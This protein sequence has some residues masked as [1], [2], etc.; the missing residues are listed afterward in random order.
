MDINEAKKLL[1]LHSCRNSDI[2]N[3]K[4]PSLKL[5]ES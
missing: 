3:P 5:T 4:S 1:S 2:N